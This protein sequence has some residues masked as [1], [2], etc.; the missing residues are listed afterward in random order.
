[1]RRILIAS[2]LAG[3]LLVARGAAVGAGQTHR[4]APKGVSHQ[5]TAG[6]TLWS[7]ARDAYPGEDPRDG[8]RRIQRANDLHS[9]LIRP[10]MRVVVP[11][12]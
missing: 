9:G 10:G 12:R 6:E 2:L 8:I 1:M 7:I 11:A 4:E 3:A 5:V